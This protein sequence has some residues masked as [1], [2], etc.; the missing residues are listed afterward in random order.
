MIS[1]RS[2]I[3]AG[4]TMGGARRTPRPSSNTAP[5]AAAATQSASLRAQTAAQ[6]HNVFRPDVYR[7]SEGYLN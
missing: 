3:D 1:F 5:A 4:P 7:V 6:S 2:I